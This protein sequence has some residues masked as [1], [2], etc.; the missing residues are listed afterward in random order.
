[1]KYIVYKITNQIN[2]KIYVG[3]HQTENLL[4]S[5][6]GSGYRL[7]RAISK[8]G[9]D[10]FTR[11]I[12]SEHKSLEEMFA[13]EAAIVDHDFVARQD[14][15]NVALGGKSGG[16]H[17]L[18]HSPEARKKIGEAATNRKH[19]A[20]SKKLMSV[21]SRGRKHSDASKSKMSLAAKK[22]FAS[23]EAR[24]ILRKA[25]SGKKRNPLSDETKLKISLAMKARKQI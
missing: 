13:A 10:A 1:M 2:G 16:F 21:A 11:E 5:Y 25:N 18:T 4:D 20:A 6:M 23:H 15:Y 14:T 17:G 8:Y 24:D 22:R 7:K 9:L 12:V 19:S 3:A